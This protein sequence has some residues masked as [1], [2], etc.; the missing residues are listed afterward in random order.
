MNMNYFDIFLSHNGTDKVWVEKLAFDIE[1]DTNGR[2]L[3]VFFDEWDIEIGANIPLEIENALQKSH[4]IGLIMSPQAFSSEWVAMERSMAMMKD[5]SAKNRQIIPIYRKPCDIP[6]TLKTIKSL[7]FSDDNEYDHSLEQLLSVIRGI[8]VKRGKNKTPEV[9]NLQE[10]QRQFEDLLY[11]FERPAF[12]ISCFCEL[13]I[14]EMLEAIDSTQ[15]ALNTGKLYARNGNLLR[16]TGAVSDFRTERYRSV[17]S[18]ILHILSKLKNDIVN[19][20]CFFELECPN[21]NYHK[22]FYAMYYTIE[23][24]EAKEIFLKHLDNMDKLRNSIIEHLNSIN[25]NSNRKLPLIKLSSSIVS[26]G[27]LW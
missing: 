6:A 5:P 20:C 17:F 27:Y 18:Q 23:K 3:R 22:N 12:R 2:P 11:A 9:V 14:S 10:D 13:F 7:D 25:H 26:R 8:P 19:F 16:E 24:K 21:Y 15:A 1:N 4:F